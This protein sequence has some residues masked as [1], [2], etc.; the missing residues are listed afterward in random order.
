L[1][2]AGGVILP[3]LSL[4]IK[5]RML[6]V[7]FIFTIAIVALIVRVAWIQF[8]DGQKL[9][10]LAFLQHNTGREIS[11]PRGTIYDRNGVELAVSTSCETISVNP[12]ELQ[13]RYNEQKINEIN[14]GLSQLLGLTD[15][16]KQKS[17]EKMKK[18]S[19][20]EKIKE[21]VDK[22][23]GNKVRQWIQDKDIFGI[24]VDEDSKRIYPKGNLASQ[25]IGFTRSDNV[26]AD[27]I[28][29]VME[30][31]LKGTK[32]KILSEVDG[33]GRELPFNEDKRIEPQSGYNVYLTIDETIQYFTEKALENAIVDYNVQEGASAIVMDPRTGDI[34]AMASK[35]DY[36]PNN[37]WAAPPGVDPSTWTGTTEEDVKKL[38][39][40]VWRNKALSDTYEPG[41]T[42]KAITSAAGL[43][44]GVITPDTIT[45][46][47]TVNVSGHNINCWRPNAHG[48]ETFAE[49]LQN[50][51]N[52]VFVKVAQSLGIS[53]FYKYV[54]A[55]GF[56]ETTGISLYGEAKSIFHTNP[57]E[58]DMATASFGQR[59]QV[60]PLQ[61]VTAYSAIANG[62]NLMKP[63][64]IKEI[65]DSEGQIVKKYEPEVV[66][67]VISEQT[68]DTLRELLEKV[69][70]QGTG[71]NAYINGYRIAG[72]TGTSETIETDKTGRYIASFAAF[73]P[74][75]NPVICAIIVLDHPAGAYHTGG[76]VAAPVAGKLVE[77]I[78][79]YLGVERRYT[80]TDKQQMLITK[81][82]PDVTGLTIEEAKNKLTEQGLQYKIEGDASNN[83]ATVVQQTPAA[84]AEVN[85]KSVVIL[86][87]YEPDQQSMVT[88]PDLTN[89]TM[90]EAIQTL[91]NLDLN[92]KTT[93]MG[94][95][96]R[97]DKKAGTKVV[98]GTI[99]NVEL[100]TNQVEDVTHLE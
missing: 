1:Y 2:I 42:F 26:G 98:K 25:V 15:E 87:T 57:Q 48:T 83:E 11:A 60:T 30:Q 88:V 100:V 44:E 5:R 74:A 84:Y 64:I 20:Y 70:S 90:E 41:S 49:G 71:S 72:K 13:N 80:E 6:V 38:Q 94:N 36:D 52:P 92:I 81:Q 65:T 63:R 79:T 22:E 4:K 82:V 78:L 56:F 93:G 76:M 46:D 86:Y 50:S 23:I 51:C 43:E 37:P 35:P 17:L 67:K 16:E 58:I 21:K 18:A 95:V 73:A 61:M 33:G 77:E 91:Q 99:I 27:G 40:T 59:F 89:K 68:S 24:N 75:D 32:G 10:K 53:R 19:R 3:G 54:K 14:E 96:V 47:A 28:E 85:D 69:V 45:S 12:K 29:A 34:L 8:V 55:F 66:R 31:Y 7:L 39:E 9:Q 97:Q 62:G